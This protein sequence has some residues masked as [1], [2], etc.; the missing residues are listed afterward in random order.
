VK[1]GRSSYKFENVYL[2]AG[3]T[4]VGEMETNGPLGKYFDI[5]ESDPYLGKK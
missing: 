4:V 3:A 1:L 2:E 5:K